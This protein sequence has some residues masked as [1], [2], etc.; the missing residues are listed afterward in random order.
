[1]TRVAVVGHVEWVDFVRAAGLPRPGEIV[2]ARDAWEA[3]AGGGAMAAYA[4]KSLTGSATF[5]CGVGDDARGAATTAGLGAAGLEVRAAVHAGR[6]Q[7]RTL[8]WLTDD[9]ERTIT[10]IGPPLEPLGTDPLS[11][12][13][14][15]A[16]DGA[17]VFAGDA[18]AIRADRQAK[19]L[20]ATARARSALL[21]AGIAVDA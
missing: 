19:V 18:D 1:M 21:E 12:E 3:P 9:H 2:A 6:A 10:T 15:A 20:V 16:F 17:V 8:T 11:W 7:P 4:L 5:F 14:L 13:E